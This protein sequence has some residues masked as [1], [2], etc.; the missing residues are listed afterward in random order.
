MCFH[1]IWI[2]LGSGF[3]VSVTPKAKRIK[4]FSPL[5]YNAGRQQERITLN[6]TGH[7]F[8]KATS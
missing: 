1:F 6:I 7:Y 2:G 5:V 8:V 3:I 4:L